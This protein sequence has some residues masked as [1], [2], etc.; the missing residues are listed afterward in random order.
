MFYKLFKYIYDI[1]KK[2]M[3]KSDNKRFVK[4]ILPSNICKETF[5]YGDKD[6]QYYNI[7]RQENLN[8]FKACIIDIHGGGFVY[9][10]KET[11]NNFNY[12]LA[13]GGYFVTTL[14]YSLVDENYLLKDQIEDVFR[15][16]N[17]L[18]R[19]YKF[20]KYVLTGD[21]AGAVLAI[22]VYV[23]NNNAELAKLYNI[24]NF[25]L[26]FKS[27]ILNHN[28]CYILDMVKLKFN[29][30]VTKLIAKPGIKRLLYGKEY[31][32]SKIL[33]TTLEPKLYINE[34][35]ELPPIL[36]ISSQGDKAFKNQTIRIYNYLKSLNKNVELYFETDKKAQH[37]FNI[38]YPADENG[39]R[40]NKMLM[41]YIDF[42]SKK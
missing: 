22:L 28:V 25:N 17:H 14:T 39:I 20:D 42:K 6:Y 12:H 36:L 30:I 27:I 23:I 31:K 5:K 29:P 9:G 16:L 34:Q 18:E 3:A 15:Y 37:V 1:I 26:D 19:K 24:E 2:E 8:Q 32:K 4:E 11:N 38:A 35:T 7:Y 40:C 33:A 13:K 41:E 21:S 10:D